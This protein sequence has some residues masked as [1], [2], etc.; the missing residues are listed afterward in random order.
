MSV[1]WCRD[2]TDGAI[3]GALST[4][5]K[6]KILQSLLA[7]RARGPC[8][9]AHRSSRRVPYRCI[10]DDDKC[11]AASI[12]I[13][14][15]SA[16]V[17]AWLRAAMMLTCGRSG[18]CSSTSLGSRLVR[19]GAADDDAPLRGDCAEHMRLPLVDALV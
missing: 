17:I 19:P 13:C 4:S 8:R 12:V 2:V 15:S 11:L 14:C 7:G 3:D 16:A 9:S 18:C 6:I 1:P 10:S 5:A